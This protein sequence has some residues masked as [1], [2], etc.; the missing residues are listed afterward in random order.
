MLE[1]TSFFQKKLKEAIE[2]FKD[3]GKDFMKIPGAEGFFITCDDK[4]G[5][6]VIYIDEINVDGV[7]YLAF[8]MNPLNL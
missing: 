8:Q 6:K 1:T 4:K 7:D 5:N 2:L 3:S